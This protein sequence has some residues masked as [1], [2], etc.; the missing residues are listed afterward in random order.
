MSVLSAV[1]NSLLQRVFRVSVPGRI[2][3]FSNSSGERVET[4]DVLAISS[5]LAC[6]RL[7]S[8]TIASLP[9]GVYRDL[10]N[11]HAVAMPEHPL[12]RLLHRAPNAEQT[13]MDFW[14]GGTASIELKGNLVARKH[15]GVSGNVVALG[16]MA[17]DYVAVKRRD[18]GRLLYGFGDEEFEP[19]DIVH[20]R[21][22]GG[23]PEG[24]LSTIALA[25][26]TFGGAKAVT[27]SANAVFKNGIRTN[28]ALMSERDL[29][30]TQMATTRALVEERYGTAANAGRPLIL[31]NGWK[32][33][34]LS[35]NPDDAQMLESRRFSVEEVCRIFGV[36]PHMIGHTEKSSSWGTGIE[37]QTLAFQKFTLRPRLK[38]IETALEQQLLTPDDI[39]KGVSIQFNLEGLL[40]A[41]S[42]AR[43][44]FYGSGLQ[45][46]WL[47]INEVRAKEGL[48]PVAGGDVPRM[49]SQ[50]VPI[51]QAGGSPDP[52][53]SASATN[54]IDGA[55]VA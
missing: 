48:P 32:A 40:R 12:W 53:A 29:D 49:Q 46:G 17:W 14:E 55:K 5:A 28:V 3:E 21:G 7:L 38:R 31:N 37:Q 45:N 43:T 50:N 25:A 6:V 44:A 2:E 10:G 27:R 41:D 30:E 23:N 11:G 19:E 33:Q 26:E 42:A 51:T 35:I 9:L 13:V 15:R 18:N 36:P 52:A 20:I 47:T 8:G 4:G 34:T 1:W 39:A 22:F 24:G 54:L 16:P